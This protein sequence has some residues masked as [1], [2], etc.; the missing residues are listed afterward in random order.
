MGPRELSPRSDKWPLPAHSSHR[1]EPGWC[2]KIV[3]W[4]PQE[5][6]QSDHKAT[7]A[8]PVPFTGTPKSAEPCTAASNKRRESFEPTILSSIATLSE[9]PSLRNL[10]TTTL[11]SWALHNLFRELRASRF[12]FH[13]A[14]GVIR[15]VA[16]SSIASTRTIIL[17]LVQSLCK[18]LHIR[19]LR[20]TAV[21]TDSS[22]LGAL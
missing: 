18:S 19:T 1:F 22:L 3:P 8:L 5:H 20:L 12:C 13:Q 17:V 21:M 4:K 15:P 16:L 10:R 14:L 6:S 7:R 2:Y 9:C 11:R